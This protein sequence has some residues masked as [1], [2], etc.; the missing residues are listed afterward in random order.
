MGF[1]TRLDFAAFLYLLADTSTGVTSVG[2]ILYEGTYSFPSLCS[3]NQSGFM[4]EG[5]PFGL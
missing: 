1:N 4:K 3:G 5:A 2:A